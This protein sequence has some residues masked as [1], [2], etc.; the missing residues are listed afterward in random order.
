MPYSKFLKPSSTKWSNTL[1]QFDRKL[2]TNYLSVWPFVGLALQGLSYT[3]KLKYWFWIN[4]LAAPMP[5]LG[6]LRESSLTHQMLTT[7]TWNCW[8][9]IIWN[10]LCDFVAFVQVNSKATLKVILLHGYFS[11][12][13]NCG[14]VTRSRN[15]SRMRFSNI[16]RTQKNMAFFHGYMGQ[17]IQ[18][19]CGRQALKN[20]N[21]LKAVFQKFYLV[22][23]EFLD[24][25]TGLIGIFFN[26]C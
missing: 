9:I 6:D 12:F 15:T 2:P 11:R 20:Y 26:I 7:L 1:K 22:R 17:G 16:E 19:I 25:Y 4:H 14:D 10:A 3:V 5:T 21:F 24:P 8:N 23:F 18:E 13:L